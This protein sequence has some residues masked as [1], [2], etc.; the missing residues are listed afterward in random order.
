MTIDLLY[1]SKTKKNQNIQD[2]S[3]N[4]KEEE[5]GNMT[6]AS[7]LTNTSN[8]TRRQPVQYYSQ[9]LNNPS[10]TPKYSFYYPIRE[11]PTNVQNRKPT[12]KQTE[13]S[14]LK[15]RGNLKLQLSVIILR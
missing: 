14:N 2:E 8:K 9:S 15:T 11:K 10:T 13:A 5:E 7:W 3:S 4:N 1:T 6:I 12:I